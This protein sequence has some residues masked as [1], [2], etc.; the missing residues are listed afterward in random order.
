[1]YVEVVNIQNVMYIVVLELCHYAGEN[2]R[3]S[4]WETFC[5][6]VDYKPSRLPSE[7][8]LYHALSQRVT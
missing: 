1:M 5:L 3:G 6:E 2:E 8:Q 4:E 7:N